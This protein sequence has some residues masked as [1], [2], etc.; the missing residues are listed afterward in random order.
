MIMC[1]CDLGY[2]W[3][4]NLSQVFPNALDFVVLKSRNN[5]KLTESYSFSDTR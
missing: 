3:D 2:C 5:H 4:G 1:L